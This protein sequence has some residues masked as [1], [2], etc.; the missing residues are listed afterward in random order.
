MAPVNNLKNGEWCK[1]RQILLVAVLSTAYFVYLAAPDVTW[2]NTD[3][4]AGIYL[5]STKNLGLSHPTGAPIYNMVGHVLT[6]GAQTLQAQAHILSLFSALAAAATSTILYLITRRFVAPIVFMASGLVV[7][8][9]YIIETYSLTTLLMVLLYYTKDKKWSYR[10]IGIISVGVHH[11]AGLALLP[12]SFYRW[13]KYGII[14]WQIL[15][16]GAFWYIYYIFAIRP[17]AAWSKVS[18][19]SYFFSQGFLTGGIDP[20]VLLERGAEAVAVIVGSFSILVIVVL[21]KSKD[22]LLNWLILLPVL[23]YVTNLAPQTYVYTMPT[24]AFGAIAIARLEIGPILR[25]LVYTSLATL[26]IFNLLFSDIGSPN[27]VDPSPTTARQYI[28]QLEALPEGS[29]VYAGTRGWEKVLAWNVEGREVCTS[30][31]RN[32]SSPPQYVS[33]VTNSTNYSADIFPCSS[34]PSCHDR[35]L[36]INEVASDRDK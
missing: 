1:V 29:V 14:D 3:A 20:S 17:D 11:L 15:P 33:I 5:W 31:I 19:S 2:I 8:Q 36:R 26:L 7:S 18:W 21:L 24:F 22:A 30:D 35:S 10:T 13:K 27:S 6:L 4:D 32:C 28:E 23:Y 25:P 16:M 9:A 34:I 12:I